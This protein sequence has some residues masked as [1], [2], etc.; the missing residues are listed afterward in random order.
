M[1]FDEFITLSGL[2]VFA[3]HF[4]NQLVERH[5]RRPAELGLGFGRIAE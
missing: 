5:L 1:L 4:R 3:Y 2:E